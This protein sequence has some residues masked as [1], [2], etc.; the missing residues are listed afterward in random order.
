MLYI[1]QPERDAAQTIA[2][3]KAVNPG[4]E[5]EI[6]RSGTTEIMAKLRR[7]VLGR[8]AAP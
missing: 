3:F 7:G 6:F 5:V 4:I 2:A 8:P 1:S